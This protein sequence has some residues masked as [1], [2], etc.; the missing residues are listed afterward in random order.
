MVERELNMNNTK[1]YDKKMLTEYLN[2]FSK[3][4]LME[5]FDIIA[6]Y[7]YQGELFMKV[8]ELSDLLRELNRQ[9]R[10]ID[11]SFPSVMDDEAK[12][13]FKNNPLYFFDYL[14]KEVIADMLSRY[15]YY[16]VIMSRNSL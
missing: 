16:N 12:E 14:K 15:I 4:Q 3:E 13:F 8:D 7:S 5:Y 9:V 11:L 6:T 2:K 10:C 1:N